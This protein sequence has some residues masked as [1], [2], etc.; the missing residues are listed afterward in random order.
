MTRSLVLLGLVLAT[1]GLQA[2][3]RFAGVR[4][5]DA[6]Q[7]CVSAKKSLEEIESRRKTL[8][9]DPRTKETDA[10]IEEIRKLRDQASD[11]KDPQARDKARREIEIKS[12]ALETTARLIEEDRVKAERELNRELVA[13][14][15]AA[16]QRIRKIAAEIGKDRGF[17]LV[18]DISGNS[19]TGVPVILFAKDLP[20]FTSDVIAKINAGEPKAES[21][22]E[23]EDAP[24]PA[25][26]ETPKPPQKDATTPPA[27]GN[28]PPPA[29][30]PARGE[31]P[32]TP[33]KHD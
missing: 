32:P 22:A 28:S 11:N 1:G 4:V 20:D 17:D 15:N 18:I 27:D 13:K 6:F 14:T 26:A 16:L 31:A 33:A 30:K 2:Q 29:G 25:P 12:G 3:T 24:A 5:S 23:S 19:N 21:K 9:A 10:M 8:A 7:A